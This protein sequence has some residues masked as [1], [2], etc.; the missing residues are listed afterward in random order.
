MDF[1]GKWLPFDFLNRMLAVGVR[2]I[3]FI[4]LRNSSIFYEKFGGYWCVCLWEGEKK[5]EGKEVWRKNKRGRGRERQRGM[6]IQLNYILLQITLALVVKNLPANSEDS[7]N[8][9]SIPGS[10]RSLGEGHG[11]PLQCSWLK[12]PVDRGA[13]QAT[14]HR[15]AKSWTRCSDL[16]SGNRNTINLA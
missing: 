3:F 1:K 13:W 14:M 4:M 7:R 5:K 9:S 10:G 16:A 8:V 12:N 11:N 6:E 15:A 2:L